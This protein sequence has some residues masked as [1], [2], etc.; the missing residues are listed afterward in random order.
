MFLAC[1]GTYFARL[2][3]SVQI[4]CLGIWRRPRLDSV[5]FQAQISDLLLG[6]RMEAKA[7]SRFA[8]F[9]R[10]GR[11]WIITPAKSH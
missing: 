7:S 10:L 11:G 5:T 6:K 3:T 4:L 9:H 8:S 1:A 2:H